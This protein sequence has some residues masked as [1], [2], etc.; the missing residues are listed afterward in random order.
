MFIGRKNI[1]DQFS[2]RHI[3]NA[4]GDSGLQVMSY[5]SERYNATFMPSKDYNGRKLRCTVKVPSLRQR[6]A[7]I[8]LNV[9]CKYIF[10]AFQVEI[11][12]LKAK[13]K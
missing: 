10:S 13:V 11:L 2:Y 8:K 7:S 12:E 4:I 5:I 9:E 3:A 1:S 6:V